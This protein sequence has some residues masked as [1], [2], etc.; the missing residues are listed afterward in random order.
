MTQSE[1]D[2]AEMQAFEKELTDQLA[3]ATARGEA[4]TVGEGPDAK[5]EAVA[6]ELRAIGLD[7]DLNV[8]KEIVPHSVELRWR[9]S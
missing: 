3:A 2:E 6:R 7:P 8:L 1:F 4:A 9:S 5:A